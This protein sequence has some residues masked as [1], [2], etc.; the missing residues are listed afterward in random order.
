M[1]FSSHAMFLFK[2]KK[3]EKYDTNMIFSIYR[4]KMENL[5]SFK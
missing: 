4:N 3:N 2:K 1:F 5:I